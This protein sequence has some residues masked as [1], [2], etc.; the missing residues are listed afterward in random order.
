MHDPIE[1]AV[2]S[3]Q[4][5]VRI[6]HPQLPVLQ[7]RGPRPA[8]GIDTE[9]RRIVPGEPI[10]LALL[11]VACD[12]S[13][14]VHIVRAWDVPA[15]LPEL[16]RL[17]PTASLIFHNASF[18][19]HAL[20]IS[21][22]F[23][24]LWVDAIS[25]GLVVDTGMRWMLR[26]LSRGDQDRRWS[27]DFVAKK[28]LLMEVPK[29]EEIRLTFSRDMELTDRHIK[30]A[31]VDAAVTVLLYREM[32]EAY[33]TEQI[34]LLGAI[35]LDAISRN[36]VMVDSAYFANLRSKF[37]A[38]REANAAVMADFGY[39]AGVSGNSAVLQR[40]LAYIEQELCYLKGSSDVA[41]AR[42]EKTGA[43][44][45][46]D[47][48]LEAMAEYPHPFLQA[49]RAHAHEQKI[50]STYFNPELICSDGRVHPR[51]SP[52]MRTGRTSCQ[53]PNMQ[54]V[55]REEGVRGMYVPTAGTLLYAADYSQL[56]LC[57]LAQSC[58]RWYGYSKMAEVINAGEDL[59]RW[60]AAVILDKDPAYINKGERQTAKAC[61]F[62]FP[63]GLG[64]AKFST[65]AKSA[66]GVTLS[67][68]ECRVL[69]DKWLA[70]FPEMRHH[71]S[72]PV[73]TQS[74]LARIADDTLYIG[75]TITGRVRRACPYCAAANYSFQGLSADGAKVALWYLF[76]EH[77]RVVN[78]IHD[79][80]IVELEPGP[81]LQDH[82]KRINA[83]LVAGMQRVIPD[84]KI[85]VEGALMDR[86]YKDAEPVVGDNGDIQLWRPPAG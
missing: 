71:L 73:D 24:Q 51:F 23:R 7:A 28:L 55:P 32:P 19:L 52:L 41:F 10:E 25:A 29:D 63:G 64:L 13:K 33:P 72:P 81:N 15:Y 12:A 47:E 36:G 59:H 39:Y 65:L 49:Y 77:Y 16:L 85:K 46:T 79:E 70:A 8:L 53:K 9:T 86:W 20:G 83:L 69:K 42:T 58:L 57:A 75:R 68:D 31:A 78:F 66:Y 76:L 2:N 43:I 82:I 4:Y 34:Q 38:K 37:E 3:D 44:Q 11:Q 21:A 22:E 80:V 18:D 27:L 50:L 6:W 84:V 61:N 35:A 40:L 48:S 67:I 30:Y 60:F 62:G 56:E 17:N 5:T 54:N 45:V 14:E 1:V 74:N 26:Q